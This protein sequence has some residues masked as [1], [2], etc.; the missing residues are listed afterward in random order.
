MLYPI[1]LR[2][3]CDVVR[4]GFTLHA[5]RVGRRCFAARFSPAPPRP[6]ELRRSRARIFAA[7]GGRGADDLRGDLL[8]PALAQAFSERLFDAAIFA[9]M[10]GED[11]DRSAGRKA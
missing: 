4:H 1:A 11:R 6:A 7:L 10:K 2:V 3:P 9:R 8:V 5:A